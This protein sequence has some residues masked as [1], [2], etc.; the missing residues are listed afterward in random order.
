MAQPTRNQLSNN[1][2]KAHYD[3]EI[4]AKQK[5]INE[6]AATLAATKKAFDE[7]VEKEHCRREAVMNR[8][9]ENVMNGSVRIENNGRP[10]HPKIEQLTLNTARKVSCNHYVVQ[11]LYSEM[12]F[13]T[14]ETFTVSPKILQ[15]AME[16]MGVKDEKEQLQL[17]EA[18]KKAIKYYVSQKRSYSKKQIK[19]KYTGK[20]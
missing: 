7:H 20:A 16:K 6:L 1:Q 4:A 2:L 9:D 19:K 13:M 15:E 17:S 3:N 14:D 18:T 5:E 8:G 12:K 10:S 11:T